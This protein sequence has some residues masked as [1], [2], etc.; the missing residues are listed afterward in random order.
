M[1]N[2]KNIAHVSALMTA[3]PYALGA[4]AET[5]IAL[6]VAALTSERSLRLVQTIAS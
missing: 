2:V 6:G 4:P 5:D 1:A 3:V